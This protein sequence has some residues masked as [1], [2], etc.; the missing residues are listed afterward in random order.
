ME[1]RREAAVIIV[2]EPRLLFFAN[3]NHQGVRTVSHRHS[4]GAWVRQPGPILLA[5]FQ[6]RCAHGVG[7]QKKAKEIL[8]IYDLLIN[9]YVT[10]DHFHV[11]VST[12]P[13]KLRYINRPNI[14]NQPV[15][16]GTCLSVCV[17]G[18]GVESFRNIWVSLS[19]IIRGSH[20]TYEGE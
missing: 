9:L 13:K 18:E 10:V 17:K 19:I 16:T 5:T 11:S 8:K 7:A 20:S 14:V 15:Q 1:C 2:H 6:C 3:L 12:L 4:V